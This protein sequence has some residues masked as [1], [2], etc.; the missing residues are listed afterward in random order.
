M[1]LSHLPL[2]A[3]MGAY[4][5]NSGLAKRGLEGQ[6]A[7]A[8]H[9]MAAGAIPQLKQVEPQRFGRMLSNA[10]IALGTALLA[11]MIPSALAGAG[12]VG[13]GSGLMQLYWKTPGM[14]EPNSPRPTQQGT[15][16][17]KDAWLVGA[18]LTLLLDDLLLRRRGGAR[19]KP[20]KR[21]TVRR[22]LRMGTS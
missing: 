12:L 6:T 16:I 3:T 7:E 2:R 17:A 4:I 15:S 20:T 21:D 18:G 19:R 10:E 1:K 13:F 9:G 5:L 8:V 14:H 22:Q 11:P